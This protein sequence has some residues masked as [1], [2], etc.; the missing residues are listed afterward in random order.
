M[1]R[2]HERERWARDGDEYLPDP[3]GYEPHHHRRIKGMLIHT[4]SCVLLA[5]P[6]FRTSIMKLAYRMRSCGSLG[7]VARPALMI[8]SPSSAAAGSM[9][10]S[11][12]NLRMALARSS[13][14]SAGEV[15][16]WEVCV[17]GFHGPGGL[18]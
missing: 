15:G 14:S 4:C 13:T 3:R 12:S 10:P 17:T 7:K 5:G 16:G 8:S 1:R 9:T 18:I 11:R 2:L 6:S